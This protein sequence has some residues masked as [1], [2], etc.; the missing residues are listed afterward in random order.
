MRRFV[1]ILVLALSI[2]RALA[3]TNCDSTLAVAITTSC[4]D[5]PLSCTAA[6][7]NALKAVV[8]S[9]CA[10]S[11][12]KTQMQTNYTTCRCARL[13]GAVAPLIVVHCSTGNECSSECVADVKAVE[14]QGGYEQCLN[15]AQVA[16]TYAKVKQCDGYKAS[17]AFA[18]TGAATGAVIAA[19]AA[20]FL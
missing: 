7:E 14:G 2:A 13:F 10:S 15:F 11:S 4:T 19:A 17:P 3:Q 20:V 8:D 5:D 6:C 9:G 18:V 16:D 12:F 1:P